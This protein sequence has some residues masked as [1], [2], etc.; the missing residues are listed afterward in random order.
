MASQFQNRLIGAVVI[1]AVGVIVLPSLFDGK[2]K[3]Y[4]EEFASI[5]L[6]PKEGDDQNTDIL[7]TVN[8]SL[9]ADNDAPE[10]AS[11]G[12]AGAN[13]A[14]RPTS[15]EPPPLVPSATAGNNQPEA[16]PE[17]QPPTK[18]VDPKP[19]ESKPVEVKP[20]T[21]ENKPQTKPVDVKPVE[22]KPV[23]AKPSKPVEAEKPPVGQAYIVQL[24][25]LKNA[26]KV[27]EIVATLRLSGYRVY[28]VPATPVQGKVTRLV[29]GP[30]TSKQKL[31]AALPE[32]K[33]LTGLNG[34]VKAYST[35]R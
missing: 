1:V 34:Q 15:V 29:V 30:D 31:E 11:N 2:K 14:Q 26:D 5:P 21:A 18:P 33:Q 28:T 32:L 8:H 3:H 4:E 10:A 7:P 9:S 6:V 17:P 13:S 25:A 19:I 12:Q 16:N 24:G 20:K 23:E 27:N 35:V 22:T